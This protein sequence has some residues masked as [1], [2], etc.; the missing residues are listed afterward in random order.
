MAV[1]VGSWKRKCA[2]VLACLTVSGRE[3]EDTVNPCNT[4]S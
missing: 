2:A 3:N 1:R 4:L